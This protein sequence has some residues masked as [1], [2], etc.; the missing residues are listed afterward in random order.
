MADQGSMSSARTDVAK[1]LKRD[2]VGPGWIEGSN[3][4]DYAEVLDLGDSNPSW[5][6]LCGYLEPPSKLEEEVTPELSLYDG[7]TNEDGE[8]IKENKEEITSELMLSPSSLGLT[9]KVTKPSIA[10]E[11]QYGTYEKTDERLWKRKH[12]LYDIKHVVESGNYYLDG[13]TG[14]NVRLNFTVAVENDGY[15]ATVRLVNDKLLP[16]NEKG[17][18]VNSAR[19]LATI[20]QPKLIIRCPEGAFVEVRNDLIS[21]PKMY[22]L[23]RHSTVLALGHNSGVDWDDSHSTVTTETIPS[24]FVPKMLPDASLNRFIPE[25]SD[26]TNED[27]LDSGL[28]QLTGLVQT[29]SEWIEKSEQS[30]LA[31]FSGE[32]NEII[33]AEIGEQIREGQLA[34]NRMYASIETLRTDDLARKAFCHS[35]QAI[36]ISQEDPS[37]TSMKKGDFKWRPF[38]IAFQLLN[39]NGL[40]AFDESDPHYSERGIVDLAW[41]PTGGGKTEA[42]LGLISFIGFYRRLKNP[43]QEKLPAVHAIMRYTLRL[44]TMDQ[45]E[46]L[47]RLM[48]G[49]NLV[50]RNSSDEGIRLGHKFRVGMW[51]GKKSSPNRFENTR[52][53]NDAKSILL[54]RKQGSSTHSSRVIMFET[55]PWC[56]TPHIKDPDNWKI[57]S[58]NNRKAIVGICPETTCLFNDESGMPFTCVD[59]DIYNNPPSVLLGTADKFVQTAY[60][61]QYNDAAD[62]HSP[63]DVRRLMGFT[64]NNSIR[65]PDLII[66]DELHLLTGPLGSMA[67]LL[68][69]ALDTAWE[70]SA[71]HKPK[72]IAAT[73]TI[74]GAERDAKLMFGRNLHV[75]PPP[76]NTATDNFFASESKDDRESSRLHLAVLGPPRKSRTLGDLPI[77]S[78]LQSANELAEQ[79]GEEI[80]DPYWTLVSYYNSLRE[81]GG[82]QSSISNRISKEWIPEYA[83][84]E[85][86]RVIENIK[87]LTSRVTQARLV[88][89]KK[90]LENS[91]MD[92]STVD[93]VAT[94][95]MFQVGIDISRLGL[96]VI[97]GQPKSNSEYIQSSGR[98]GRSYPGLVVSLLRSTYPRDQSHYE[99]HRAF[100]QE[101]YRHVDQ[102]S[103]TPF[104]LRA[105]DRSLDTTLMALVRMVSYDV[106]KNSKLNLISH[107]D[108]RSI[109]RPIENAIV[110]F[111]EKIQSRLEETQ[112][113]AINDQRY[114]ANVVEQIDINWRRLKTWVDQNA[115][116]NTCYWT[117][118]FQSNKENVVWWAKS[119]DGANGEAPMINTLRDVADEVPVALTIGSLN[120][121]K[122]DWPNFKMPMGHV[123]SYASS[124]SIWEKDG[125]S[126]LT[127]G[128]SQWENRV[129]SPNSPLDTIV[130][131]GGCLVKERHIDSQYGLLGPIVKQ[132]R[133]PPTKKEQGF[134]TATVF[135][136]SFTCTNGHIT[137]GKLV[138]K[139]WSC[140]LDGCTEK[141]EQ[142]R[143]VSVCPD[144]HL[145]RFDY[146]WWVH[147]P[148][149]KKCSASNPVIVLKKLK[150][151]AYDLSKW[152]LTCSSC[153]AKANMK[154]VPLVSSNDKFGTKCGKHGEPWLTNDWNE[155]S[156]CEQFVEHR[157]VGSA[158]VTYNHD[159]SILLI[160]LEVSWDLANNEAVA[161]F[162]DGNMTYEDMLE[163]YQVKKSRG[164]H[165]K[166]EQ[167]LQNTVFDKRNGEFDTDDFFKHLHQYNQMNSNEPLDMKTIRSKERTGLSMGIKPD[168]DTRFTSTKIEFSK[169][170]TEQNPNPNWPISTMSRVD[171]LTELRFITGL[172]RILD[173]NPEQP[174]DSPVNEM[175]TS[176][177]ANYNFGEG[178][179]F[180]I[181]SEWLEKMKMKRQQAIGNLSAMPF[182]FKPGRVPSNTITQ[183]SSLEDPR[184]RNGFTILHSL[185][186]LIIKQLCEMSGYSLGSIRER[187]YFNSEEGKTISAGILVY[188]SGPSSD[189]T[190]GG[191]AGQANQ[192]R[193]NL[194]MSQ[195]LE[196]RNHCSNDPVCAEHRPTDLE[197]NGAACH[198]CLILPET[199]CEL[200]N[201]LLDRK[202]GD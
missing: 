94:S 66:Q 22:V 127:G 98:I 15:R 120:G 129:G 112:F 28:E 144:G 165:T 113:K 42:Y 21:D 198:T 195:A 178:I 163:W 57:G 67:G 105:L 43:E 77:A 40:I 87:E 92:D 122:P 181:N 62:E 167:L 80:T 136:R 73:A 192:K 130:E 131:H 118:P 47:V 68:E 52:D 117:E 124:G 179:Y 102:T 194:I 12:H 116:E 63:L 110:L 71:N 153:G 200:R 188:T 26:L 137:N 58:L 100:H 125:L 5:R 106:A 151:H 175:N 8:E 38:Q 150:G 193:I 11:V 36:Q 81:L 171:R 199:S 55:C 149:N 53:G 51:I 104:S 121:K 72:Y 1:R 158:S 61:R 174:I 60:N 33:S 177:I 97:N 56:G 101:L 35:N 82:L 34:V 196:S 161:D 31:D 44:L 17:K 157:Q 107:G 154:N 108:R 95:N 156:A 6:Y 20:Y 119:A 159:S 70:I 45:G 30:M 29:Y 48:G 168:L 23:Y 91:L 148:P 86:L 2:L 14:A 170:G 9:F 134:V 18:P 37:V 172:S 96:M 184:N 16:L 54:A 152:V 78:L 147:K 32:P 142:N 27:R 191:L 140:G 143:F 187:L 84:N 19:A 128:L 182:S 89:A 135:P 141:A 93:V 111:K 109:R 183:I 103:T 202:W 190:L 201:H 166:I 123:I 139:V 7:A 90:S 115:Q 76:I 74:R 162:V 25:M 50:A 49:M 85:S 83:G 197:P 10:I 126:Y 155:R 65:P 79:Y 133:I 189:G 173:S 164:M 146:S 99:T 39:I 69:T 145:H 138:N 180:E 75:F 176:G 4:S 114:I 132:L 46:R 3:A 160:P 13:F 64:P 59:E 88:E 185:S 41:F 186:H 24:H 169:Y